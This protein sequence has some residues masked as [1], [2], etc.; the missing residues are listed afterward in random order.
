MALF[1]KL[2]FW[3][4]EDEF[5]EQQPQLPPQEPMKTPR[6]SPL[7]EQGFESP[8]MQQPLAPQQPAFA[9]QSDPE[10]RVISAKLETIKAMLDVI[11]QRLDRLEKSRSNDL[12]RWH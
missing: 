8:L 6:F 11:N 12:G 1:K 4:H 2:A 5:E 7:S 9:Q 3:K 10:I